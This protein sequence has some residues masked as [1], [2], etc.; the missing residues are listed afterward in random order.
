MNALLLVSLS[1]LGQAK[2]DDGS[3]V[4]L[5]NCNY[6]VERYTSAPIGHVAVAVNEEQR[7]WIYEATPGKVRRLTW[8]DYRA[9]LAKLNA[10]RQRK[11]KQQIV[12][13]VLEPKA[14]LTR[15]Q[16]TDLKCYLDSQLD[17]RYSVKGIVRG[18]T[19]DGIHCAE[20]ASQALNAAGLA[21]IDDCHKQSPAA[22]RD[23]AGPLCDPAYRASVAAQAVEETWCQRAWR[24]WTHAA[25]MCRW[26][27]GEAWRFC[28]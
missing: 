28:W 26:S 10:D 4:V 13:W 24:R 5:E 3:L 12:T 8:D 7:T 22:V 25:V 6:W 16:A 2:L 1:L 19:G 15:Q 27:W 11:K 23:I 21:D 20:L 18:K 9:E 14:A 17:R